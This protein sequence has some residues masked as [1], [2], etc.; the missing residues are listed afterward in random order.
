VDALSRE[1][2]SELWY[3]FS[4]RVPLPPTIATIAIPGSW[5]LP[6]MVFGV[7]TVAKLSPEDYKSLDLIRRLWLLVEPHLTH[8]SSAKEFAEIAQDM[9]PIVRELLPGVTTAAQR[10]VIMLIQRQSLR[11][12][13]D[14]DGHHSVGEWDRD[15]AAFA[16][17]IR[18]HR[19]LPPPGQ[20][21]KSQPQLTA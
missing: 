10:F 7:N 4:K 12:A 18:P 2:L 9:A 8:P 17:K 11:L 21:P 1:A 14:L 3:F 6:G 5:P 19:G 20:S 13:D 15:P 16:R